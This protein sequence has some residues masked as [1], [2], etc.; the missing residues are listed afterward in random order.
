MMNRTSNINKSIHGFPINVSL[1]IDGTGRHNISTGNGMF[2]HLLQ[3]FSKHGNFNID[4]SCNA[5]INVDDHH[6]VD[7]IGMN[8]GTAFKRA[9]ENSSTLPINRY[10]FFILPMDEVLT[11]CAVDFCNRSS[12]V[13]NVN[14]KRDKIGHLSTEMIREFWSMFSQKAEINFIVKSEYGTNDH[15][16]AEGLFKCVSKALSM[17]VSQKN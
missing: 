3:L 13:F 6:L 10:G 17:A 2:D 1:N 12:F 8:L 16:V 5:D 11:T 7:E 9:I 14:F 4:I 15:H